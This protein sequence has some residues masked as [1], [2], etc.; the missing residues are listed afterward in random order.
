MTLKKI[1]GSRSI[2]QNPDSYQNVTDPQHS[3]RYYLRD[4]FL[5][6]FVSGQRKDCHMSKK[7]ENRLTCVYV[8]SLL[9]SL[10]LTLIVVQKYLFS[11]LDLLAFLCHW[12]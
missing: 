5:S 3:E 8:V 1:A 6:K 12:L 2:S 4:L 10:E 9:L 11:I 7:M